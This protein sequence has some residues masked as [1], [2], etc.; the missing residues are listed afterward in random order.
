MAKK[1]LLLSS[2]PRRNGNSGLLCGQFGQGAQ[3]AG[4]RAERIFLKDKK[5]NCCTGYG[6]ST[7]SGA[8]CPQK[9]DMA[10]ILDRM[11][12]ATSL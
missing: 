6:T 4:H 9:D 2:S 11:V 3:D 12:A 1:V 5:I 8:A 10:E 7:Q